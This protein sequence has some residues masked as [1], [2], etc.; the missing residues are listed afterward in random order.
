M[1]GGRQEYARQIGSSLDNEHFTSVEPIRKQFAPIAVHDDHVLNVPMAAMRLDGEH[2]AFFKNYVAIARHDRL[3]L[4]PPAA[5]AM[6][7][8]HWL[9]LPSS[10]VEFLNHEPEQSRPASFNGSIVDVSDDLIFAP[11]L[12]AGL[13]QNRVARLMARIALRAIGDVIVADD[14]ATLKSRV[15]FPAVVDGI[16]AGA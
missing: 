2:H 14:I 12:V 1:E 9:V 5:D 8:Q 15:T 13:S 4:V 11:L 3:L 16:R 7:D 10:F 6:P